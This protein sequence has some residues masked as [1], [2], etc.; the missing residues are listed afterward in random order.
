MRNAVVVGDYIVTIDNSGCIGEKPLDAVQTTNEI[1]AYFT[2][3]TAIVEQWCAG[4]RPVQLL[5]ANFTGDAAWDGY[6][7]GIT[8]V[9]AEIGEVLPPLTGSTESNFDSAQSAV[10]LTMIGERFFTPTK[11][12]CRYFVIGKP[13]VGKQVLENPQHVAN[14]GELY[15]LL[16]E[17]VIQAVWPTGSK[18]IGAEITRFLGAHYT[19][20]IDLQHTAGPTT[21]VLVAVKDS[22]VAKLREIITA[23]ITEI[24][25]KPKQ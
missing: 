4:A 21:A 5:L 18:G 14:L 20:D 3:R 9:F 7:R 2:A 1:T 24:G 22:H 11:E 12:A 19:C 6:V 17:Q 13:L 15:A 16:K 25:E 10:A 8:K 23:P